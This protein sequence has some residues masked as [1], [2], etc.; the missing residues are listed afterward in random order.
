MKAKLFASLPCWTQELQRELNAKGRTTS[1]VLQPGLYRAA[2]ITVGAGLYPAFG[3]APTRLNIADDPTRDAPL[4][5]PSRS[6][7]PCPLGFCSASG[8]SCLSVQTS[9]C[10][11]DSALSVAHLLPRGL[12]LLITCQFISLWLTPLV[13][14]SHCCS[15]LSLDFSHHWWFPVFV[16]FALVPWLCLSS[17]SCASD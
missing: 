4:R 5:A 7:L 11:L 2:A 8:T 16:D 9:L 6:F 3:F 13:V 1:H 14:F 12:C 10:Q 15:S 17:W